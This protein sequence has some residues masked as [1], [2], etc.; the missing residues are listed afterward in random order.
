MSQP[1]SH[2][3]SKAL[4]YRASQA[5]YQVVLIPS[6]PPLLYVPRLHRV[7]LARQKRSIPTFS[8][9]L[10]K[11]RILHRKPGSTAGADNQTLRKSHVWLQPANQTT[12]YDELILLEK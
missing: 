9:S 11:R 5:L 7:D 10:A 3:S 6:C 8:M 2:W 1:T 4:L 12:L